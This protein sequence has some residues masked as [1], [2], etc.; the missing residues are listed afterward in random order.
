MPSTSPARGQADDSQVIVTY[1]PLR[2]QASG[3]H[4]TAWSEANMGGRRAQTTHERTWQTPSNAYT[5]PFPFCAAHRG[6]DNRSRL[7]SSSRWGPYTTLPLSQVIDVTTSGTHASMTPRRDSP[8]LTQPLTTLLYAFALAFPRHP[9]SLSRMP[10]PLAYSP[11][12]I[13]SLP[14]NAFQRRPPG[15]SKPTPLPSL[16]T[17]A[18]KPRP[19]PSFAQY[20]SLLTS[21]NPQTVA[22]DGLQGTLRS[23][24]TTTS[25]HSFASRPIRPIPT[26]THSLPA[27]TPPS[28]LAHTTVTAA[29]PIRIPAAVQPTTPPAH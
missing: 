8:S 2:L 26:P 18:R 6:G 25:A 3:D 12:R 24:F 5:P 14:S 4:P 20:T 15:R 22:V 13:P 11:R 27:P 17:N 7:K 9:L 23:L 19:H 28:P 10:S 16:S 21:S 29:V 1:D